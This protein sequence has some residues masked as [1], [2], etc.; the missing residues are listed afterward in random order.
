MD[1]L[2]HIA[3]ALPD[4]LDATTCLAFTATRDGTPERLWLWRDNSGAGLVE[5]E[6]RVRGLCERSHPVD[7]KVDQKRTTAVQ[8][9]AMRYLRP[10]ALQLL[11][12]AEGVQLATVRACDVVELAEVHRP[13]CH[14]CQRARADVD[15]PAIGS[16]ARPVPSVRRRRRA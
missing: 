1:T 11:R 8:P 12:G 2:A 16:R 7:G 4:A 5:R 6:P 15:A 3:A 10:V 14:A 9:F 13:R